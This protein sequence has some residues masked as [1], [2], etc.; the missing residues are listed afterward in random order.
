MR[1]D[2]FRRA[3]SGAALVG[4][5][6]LVLGAQPGCASTPKLLGV[7]RAELAMPTFQGLGFNVY[8][9]VHNENSFDVAIRALRVTVSLQ[10]KYTLQ[11]IQITPN[12]WLPA[13]QTSL[14]QIPLVI[15]WLM[16][17]G[18]LAETLGNDSVSFHVTGS[19]DV[20]ATQAFNIQKDNYAVDETGTVPRSQL[21]GAARSSIPG[22]AGQ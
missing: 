8:L 16:I 7:Q 13:K 19:A 14:V 12:Q 2:R 18:V 15:P 3:V 11:P 1:L 4:A 10:D 17:P 9:Q 20:S 22:F 6:L 5:S 21:L